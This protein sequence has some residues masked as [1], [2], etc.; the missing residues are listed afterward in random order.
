MVGYGLYRAKRIDDAVRAGT[1]AEM[2]A[3][4]MKVMTAGTILLALAT[5]A[6]II[7]GT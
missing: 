5:A 1:W 6:L 3:S 2:D 4:F 7:V